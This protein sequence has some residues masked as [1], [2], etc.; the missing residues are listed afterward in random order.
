[1]S[2]G[3]KP[4][5]IVWTEKYR[6]KKVEDVVGQHKEKVL[7]YL[8]NPS[9]IPHF[10]LHSVTPG[11]G[12]CVTEDEMFIT[13]NGLISFKDY[14]DKINSSN[15][16]VDIVEE[17]YDVEKKHFSKS[18]Y[19]YQSEEEV[20]EIKSKLGY[21]IK[22]TPEHKIKVFNREAGIIWKKLSDINRND[23]ILIFY[24]TQVFG[25]NNIL[26]YTEYDKIK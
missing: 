4:K 10:L 13:P 11:T 21:G 3:F 1:M 16:K 20:I 15:E 7:K 23:N 22:G 12:K 8:E 17:L 26:D 2:E 19:F 18:E 6:P 5:D 14:K 25:N 24:N 9:S